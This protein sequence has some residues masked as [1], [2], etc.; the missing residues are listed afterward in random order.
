[1]LYKQGTYVVSTDEKTGIQAL[2]RKSPRRPVR[3]GKVEKQAFEY[4]G[5]GT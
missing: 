2:E 4:I 1:V 3:P 5:H